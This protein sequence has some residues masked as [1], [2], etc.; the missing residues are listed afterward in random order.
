M[1]GFCNFLLPLGG[2]KNP[3]HGKI[4][5]GGASGVSGQD[6]CLLL[7]PN[8]F[9]LLPTDQRPTNLKDEQPEWNP[10]ALKNFYGIPSKM[11]WNL[12]KSEQIQWYAMKANWSNENPVQS[13]VSTYLTF[14]FLRCRTFGCIRTATMKMETWRTLAKATQEA[15]LLSDVVEFGNLSGWSRFRQQ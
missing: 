1:Y 9:Y 15:L 5:P 6:K 14:S 12:S 4:P 8:K 13:S 7:N 3:S 2:F 11:L 10:G